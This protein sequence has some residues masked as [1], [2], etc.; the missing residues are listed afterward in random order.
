I[1]QMY[2]LILGP[3]PPHVVVQPDMTHPPR[4][5]ESFRVAV[6][7]GGIAGCSAAT[8]LA[9]RGARVT[10]Y[11]ASPQLGGRAAAWPVTLADG[12]AVVVDH[13]FH[14][15]FRQYYNLRRMLGRVGARLAPLGDY[16]AV[17]PSWP[18]ESFARLPRRAP[19]SLIA[20]VARSPSSRVRDLVRMDGAAASPPLRLDP[21]STFADLDHVT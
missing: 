15:Y 6:I 2:R 8:V 7:G 12:T 4:F 20:L 14:G 13:G 21:E 9:E 17:S 18:K 1:R 11:E 10:L 3:V 19:W 5:R 16:P